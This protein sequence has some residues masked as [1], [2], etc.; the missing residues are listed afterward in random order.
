[1]TIARW[2]EPF[3]LSGAPHPT[4]D[5]PCQTVMDSLYINSAGEVVPCA[6]WLHEP[7]IGDF[8]TQDLEQILAAPA[9]V[10]ARALAAAGR[11]KACCRKS[12]AV[13][14]GNVNDP[15]FF[16]SLRIV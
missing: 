6:W 1:M 10:E 12:C 2:P 15:S 13:R 7:P 9:L 3:D 8:K 5:L 11:L 16:A 14:A 4:A